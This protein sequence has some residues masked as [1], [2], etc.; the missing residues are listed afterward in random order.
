[1]TRAKKPEPL[2]HEWLLTIFTGLLVVIGAIYSF[3][4][5]LHWRNMNQQS[6][7]IAQQAEIMKGQLEDARLTRSGDLTLRLDSLLATPVNTRLRITIQSGQKPKPI[8]KEHGA[9]FTD[10]DLENYLGIFDSLGDLYEKGMIDKDSFYN[11]YSYD[12][13]KACDNSEIKTYLRDIRREEADFFSDF[14]RIAN[15]MKN[16]PRSTPTP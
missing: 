3:T 10:D 2:S 15:K 11:D 9:Q 4:T 5:V 6:K 16:C 13:E 12:I 8:L 14:D 7:L 1:M